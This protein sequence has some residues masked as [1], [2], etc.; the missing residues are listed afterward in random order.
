MSTGR[1]VALVT[2]AGR[3]LGRAC[4]VRLARA[5]ADVALLDIASDLPDIPYPLATPDNL[6]DT[7][8][9]CRELGAVTVV[10]TADVRKQEQ[11]SAAVDDAG[12]RLGPI[13][14]V[15][16]AAGVAAPSGKP[17]HEISE[18][19]WDVMLDVDLSGAW[20]VIKATAPGMI[21]NG[22]G[23]IVNISSTAG[24][25][26]YGYFAGYVSAKHGLI[27]LTRAAALDYASHRIRVNAVCPGQVME[28]P[29]LEGR[30]LAEVA[31]SLG[32]AP[33]DEQAEFLSAQPMNSLVRPEDVAGAVAW[34][35]GLE[36]LH[37][38]GSVITVDGGFSIK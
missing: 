25:V 21:D 2:G 11:V 5:G 17:I 13:N 12:D 28:D 20:R 15:V 7:E 26:G 6:R 4:A 27:G 18:A 35:A 30:M 1:Q 37:V 24:L 16:N 34:L 31:R 36:S 10:V 32:V 9:L 38:T 8:A 29:D 23:S 33:E 22:G 19:E 3:G 14:V